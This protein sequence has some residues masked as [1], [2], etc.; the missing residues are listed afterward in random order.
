MLSKAN[1]RALLSQLKFEN[2]KDI[3][4]KEFEHDVYLKVDFST[5]QFIYPK[6]KGFIVN[7]LQTCNFSANE[8]FVVF[9]CVHRLLSQGYKPSHIELEPKWKVGHGASGGRA[10]ILI[11]DN[12]N[13]SYLIIECKTAGS[14]F[15]KAWNATQTRPT[16]LFSYAQQERSTKFIALDASDFI[17]NKVVS[18]YFLINL[19]DL[20]DVFSNKKLKSYQDATTVEEIYQVWRD[21]CS[22]DYTSFGLFENN[23]AYRIGEHKPILSV[24]KAINSN[25]IQGKYHE[26]ATILRQHNVSGR[27]NAFDK[28]VNLF[29]CKVVDEKENPQE[30]KFYWNGKAYDNPFDFQDRLQFLYKNGM[31]KFLGETITYIDNS[32]IDEAFAVFKNKPNATKDKIKEFL[33]AQKFFTNSDFAFI[34]VH[35]EKLFYQNFD[36]LLKISR[37]IQDISL[38]GS[39]ENQFLGDMFEGFLDQ[40]VKQSEG[41]FFTPMPIVKF[42]I[43]S[44]PHK[45]NPQ[46]IDYACGAGHFLNEYATNNQHQEKRIV[47]IEKEYRLSK[48]AKVSSFMYGGEIEIIY[49]DALKISDKI[50]DNSFDVLIANPPYSV[51]GF[52]ETLSDDDRS[53]FELIKT[54]DEKSYSTNNAIECFFIERAKQLLAKDGVAGIIVPSSI[55]NKGSKDNIYVATREILLKYFDIV[56]IAEF[57][58]GT[59]GKTGTNTVTLFL[60][61]RSDTQDYAK[62]YKNMVASWF[63]CDFISN[64]EFTDSDLLERYCNHIALDFEAYQELLQNKLS[65]SL[66]KHETFAEYK[67]EFE[68]L[69]ETKNRRNKKFYKEL[70]SEQ[71]DKKET[72][73]V[74]KYIKII[75][76]DKLYYFCLAAK[77]ARDVIIVKSPSDS[78]DSKKFLGYEWSS[79]KGNEGIKYLT[80]NNIL[81][82]D[83]DLE[84]EDKRILENLQGLKSINTPLYNPQNKTDSQ[85]INSIIANNFV[86]NTIDIPESLTQFVSKSRLIDMLDFSRVEFNKAISLSPSKKLEIES[87]YPLVKLSSVL[88][89]VINGS[90]PSKLDNRYWSKNDVYWL[91]TPDIDDEHIYVSSASQYVSQFAISENKINIVP[92]GA[93][94][95]TCTAT[96]GKVAITKVDLTTNQQINAIVCD[97]DKV[98]PEFVAYFMKTQ[99]TNLE[100]LTTNSGVKHINIGM[101]NNFKIPLPPMEIQELIV[102]ECQKVD[103]EVSN[104]QQTIQAAKQSIEQLINY[105]SD[106]KI[107]LG[108]LVIGSPQYGANEKAV[109]GNLLED[110]RYIRIT[111]INDSGTLNSEFKT[112]EIIEDKYILEEGD[113]L[114]ARS[115]NTV[116]K[117][118]LYENKY[119]RC[120]YAGYLIRFRLNSEKILPK[121]LKAFTTTNN[122]WAWIKNSQTG[123]SQ[124]NINGQI[125]MTLQ[126]PLPPIEKQKEIVVSI[127]EFEQQIANAQQMIDNAKAQKQV[128]LNKYL[129]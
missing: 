121:Y 70:T 43:N 28:L 116:G 102:A 9:E 34:E 123:A 13:K 98:I 58:S 39:D 50:H 108:D 96:I 49:D 101:L 7:E 40:G 79:A 60:Q 6:N 99:K 32:Q 109:D 125:Y 42:I 88:S 47:G 97:Y 45:S 35:N 46:V 128:I 103:V 81:I 19:F 90:T 122:Y 74:I 82:N 3:F 18:N 69:T 65:E 8:N 23:Q 14:E 67:A 4:Y 112:A 78:K 20:E 38:T 11:K 110:V 26:F 84:E 66:F 29:L 36:V 127:E 89:K 111:D 5:E 37:M 100:N 56:A 62:H 85:K 16:Q 83:E 72:A 41:Q 2:E 10:D 115:G 22:R 117:T 1:F 53:K 91:T 71:Q 113:F 63:D 114:F 54:I 27:E 59:F 104:A 61:R 48:V 77:N 87:K 80:S 93:V 129:N 15:D 94:I 119:G 86:G 92:I 64:Q 120:L 95:I 57:G 25:D 73:E 68:K 76:K 31:E 52:L 12:N 107:K 124:P 51:K 21:T 33:R 105:V 126:I 118:F 30:L 55:L 106:S 17:D 75:E 44:L 24:L